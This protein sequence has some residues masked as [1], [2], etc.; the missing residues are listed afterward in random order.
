MDSVI[1][2]SILI[3]LFLLCIVGG[4]FISL[5]KARRA[6]VKQPGSRR[7]SIDSTRTSQEAN[8]S[9]GSCGRS[10]VI[11]LD[12]LT[13]DAEA[14]TRR[15]SDCNS[16]SSL[17]EDSVSPAVLKQVH[18]PLDSHPPTPQPPPTPPS[19]AAWQAPR[20]W[21][22]GIVSTVSE[23]QNQQKIGVLSDAWC[24]RDDDLIPSNG[25][26]HRRDKFEIGIAR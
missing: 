1:I 9:N 21:D 23:S 18:G 2:G 5:M 7:S 24:S 15:R 3:A 22:T 8:D 25:H 10:S 16:L 4:C 14:T 17:S 11:E 26:R 20:E 12:E 6:A 13:G 19:S